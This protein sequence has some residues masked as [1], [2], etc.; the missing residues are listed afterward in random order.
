[1]AGTSLR[2]RGSIGTIEGIRWLMAN[3]QFEITVNV[4]MRTAYQGMSAEGLNS[5]HF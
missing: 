1:M 4:S 5:L 2:D 3:E